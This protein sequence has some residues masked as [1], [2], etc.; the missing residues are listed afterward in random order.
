MQNP[1]AVGRINLQAGLEMKKH[2][3]EQQTKQGRGDAVFGKDVKLP[4]KT[5][6]AAEDDCYDLL[7]EARWERMPVQELKEYWKRIP[8]KRTHIYRRLPLEHH[9]AGG[10]VSECVIVRAHDRSLPLKLS[11]FY[12]ANSTKKSLGS[13]EV[14]DAADGWE[15]PRGILDIQEALANMGA[16]FFCLWHMDPTPGILQRLLTY[17]NF[18][19]GEDRSE[20]DQCALITEVI[21]DI[22]RT[23]ASRAIGREP[24]L[25]FRECRERW[26]DAAEKRP[27]QANYKHRRDNDKPGPSSKD[28]RSKPDGKTAGKFNSRSGHLARSRVMKHNGNLICFQYNKASG[29]HRKSCVSFQVKYLIFIIK[30]ISPFYLL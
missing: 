10:A 28:P 11:M 12:K 2:Y 14:K 8:T 13:S 3:E 24:P 7:H 9:G 16:I 30:Q 1:L 19:T 18:G 26:K 20:K 29:C 5:F 17:Y 22:L 25:S 4:T 23:N 27:T 15:N 6:P 21:D